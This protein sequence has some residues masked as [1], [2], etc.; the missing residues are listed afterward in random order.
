[1]DG[2]ER[3]SLIV[4]PKTESP[5]GAPVVFAFHGHGGTMRNSA[6]TFR[7]HELWPEALV[8]Y[9]Q[10]LPTKGKF[11]PQGTRPGWQKAVGE[12]QDRDL[13]FFD[14]LLAEAKAKHKIDANRVY[15]MGHSNGGGFTYLLWSA[16]HAEL[17]AVAP[18]AAG[19]R[20]LRDLK[21][22]PAL[23]I[24]GQKDTTVPFAGQE[25]VMKAVRTVNGC[26]ETGKEWAKDCL[27]HES[28]KGGPFVSFIHA[29]DHKFPE[30]APAHIVKF[31]KEQVRKP[32]ASPA[33]P[34]GG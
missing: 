8:I 6:R 1:V 32:S 3:E 5:A 11:D 24:A 21:P 30:E 12:E 9:P 22:L 29:G 7:I 26:A 17:A 34:G 15:V 28:T 14:A 33:A 18:S 19:G 31:F 13:K 27:V 4:A 10:G 16:R 23:H 20:N 2:V 25:L